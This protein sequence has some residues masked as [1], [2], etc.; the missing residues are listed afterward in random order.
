VFLSIIKLPSDTLWLAG[1]DSLW[2]TRIDNLVGIKTFTAIRSSLTLFHPFKTLLL[3]DSTFIWMGT[4]SS[5]LVRYDIKN[6]RVDNLTTV[7]RAF[8]SRSSRSLHLDST[9][10][11]WIGTDRGL[12]RLIPPFDFNAPN[13]QDEI[14][15]GGA[16]NFVFSTQNGGIWFD[17]RDGVAHYSQE[18]G[19][20]HFPRPVKPTE[21]GPAS[22]E[23]QT[24]VNLIENGRESFWFGTDAGLSIFHGD[25]IP[26]E[27]RITRPVF[28]D[29]TLTHTVQIASNTLFVQYEGGDNLT[30]SERSA[31]RTKLVRLIDGRDGTVIQQKPF[32][33]DRA[34]QLFFLESGC[35]RYEVQARDQSGNIDPTPACLLIEVDIDAP[36]VVITQPA[37]TPNTVPWVPGCFVVE[38]SVVDADLDSFRVEIVNPSTGDRLLPAVTKRRAGKGKVLAS[39]RDS[40]LAEFDVR[41]LNEE[42]III[43]VTAA[44]TLK[45]S[46]SDSVAVRVDAV[47]P[48]LEV[49]RPADGTQVADSVNID[50]R[51]NE[52]HHRGT[53]EFFFKKMS[54]DTTRRPL[55]NTAPDKIS[56]DPTD[57]LFSTA[58]PITFPFGKEDTLIFLFRDLAGNLATDVLTLFRAIPAVGSASDLRKSQDDLVQVHLPPGKSQ[59]IIRISPVDSAFYFDSAISFGLQPKSRAYLIEPQEAFGREATLTMKIAD[60]FADRNRLA[61]FRQ[62]SDAWNHVGGRF[63]SENGQSTLRAVINRGGVYL[64]AVGEAGSFQAGN[65]TCLPRMF[66][67]GRESYAAFTDVVFTLDRESSVSIRIYNTAGRQVRSLI[68]DG[69]VMPPGRH[70]VRWD[71]Y[72]NEKGERLRSGIYIVVVRTDAFTETKTVVIQ[73]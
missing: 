5:G 64:A 42:K 34:E 59:I 47:L 25:L 17:D 28:P 23:V 16:V 32:S 15:T 65:V 29:T 53:L 40:T 70:A 71:G 18:A 11:L 30:A 12:T 67:P 1:S 37:A 2:S 69:E 55:K 56:S 4:E 73:K 49:L 51:F 8:A 48:K 10:V 35:Y 24:G 44:D 7:G 20:T 6:R 27:T 63:S 3:Q 72:G 52:R 46:R 60:A 58:I 33:P 13:W 66:S 39:V 31:F 9:G 26:P 57:S 61:I 45:H 68:N 50:F 38:G 54:T 21:G 36:S 43:R 62:E 14:E 22:K 19:V 41:K